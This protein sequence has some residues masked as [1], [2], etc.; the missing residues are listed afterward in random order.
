M[1]EKKEARIAK[2]DEVLK[3]RKNQAI[4]YQDIDRIGRKTLTGKIELTPEESRQLKD[5][6]KEAI[7]SRGTIPDLKQKLAQAVKDVGIWKK[8]YEDLKEQTKDFLAAVKKA[9]EKVKAFLESIIQSERTEPQ[10]PRPRLNRDR[11]VSR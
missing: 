11:S 8:R 9:P 4:A 5:L 1:A 2:A 10:R 3:V 6:A 7:L